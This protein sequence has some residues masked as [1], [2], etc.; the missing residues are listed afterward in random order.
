MKNSRLTIVSVVALLA[1]SPP[2]FAQAFTVT[3]VAGREVAFDAPVQRAILGEGRL[4]YRKP[5]TRPRKPLRPCRRLAQRPVDHRHRVVQTPMSR[6][7]PKRPTCPSW[8]TSPTAPFSLKPSSPEARRA[9]PADRQQDRGR[10]DQARRNDGGHWREDR[11]C[12]FPR[13]HRRQHPF[14]ACI[15]LAVVWQGSARRRSGR[16]LAVPRWTQLPRSSPPTIPSVPMSSCIAPR[17][18]S[19]AAAPSGRTISA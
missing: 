8:A 3:D 9:D 2:A 10:R 1:I 15:S 13:A 12:R 16:F 4:L 11:L 17:A 6:S 14:P 18:W 19:N 5:R 7:F